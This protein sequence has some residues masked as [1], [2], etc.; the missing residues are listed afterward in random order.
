L[1]KQAGAF[2]ITACPIVTL[3]AIT[4]KLQTSLSFSVFVSVSVSQ[5][6]TKPNK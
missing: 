4:S 5:R 6:S 3:A 2:V 1:P